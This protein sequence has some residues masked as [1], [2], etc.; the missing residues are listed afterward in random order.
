MKRMNRVALGLMH[1]HAL[2]SS[3]HEAARRGQRIYLGRYEDIMPSHVPYDPQVMQPEDCSFQQTLADVAFHDYGMRIEYVDDQDGRQSLWGVWQ[4]SAASIALCD[5]G[6]GGWRIIEYP[7]NGIETWDRDTRL[8]YLI[9]W[10]G[11]ERPRVVA[12]RVSTRELGLTLNR[13]RGDDP[14]PRYFAVPLTTDQAEAAAME[15]STNGKAEYVYPPRSTVS[16]FVRGAIWRLHRAEERGS[17]TTPS[18]ADPTTS[19]R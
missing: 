8:W 4:G 6:R 12:S 18:P 16:Q 15:V 9:A 10:R 2:L 5:Q 19:I 14:E 17:V 11:Y 13:L 7:R 3:Q 1:I